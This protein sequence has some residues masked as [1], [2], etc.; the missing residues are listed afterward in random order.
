MKTRAGL[1]DDSKMSWS[2]LMQAHGE[3]EHHVERRRLIG[4]GDLAYLD[5]VFLHRVFA[6]LTPLAVESG[7]P[8]QL[9]FISNTGY[10]PAFQLERTSDKRPLQAL[11]QIPAQID[12]FVSL[13][14]ARS[15]RFLPLEE[16]A[17]AFQKFQACVPAIS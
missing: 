17:R 3:Q 8:F 16:S 6:V 14:A 1:M 5:D 10:A 12:R 11:L 9:P 15:L 13:P 2:I 7:T 4:R